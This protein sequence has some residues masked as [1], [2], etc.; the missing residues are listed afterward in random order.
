M[1]N[2]NKFCSNC[3]EKIDSKAKIRPKCGVPIAL[4][5]AGNVP[6]SGI[7]VLIYTLSIL[8]PLV[9]IIIGVIYWT[10]PNADKKAFGKACV[11]LSLIMVAI[12][13]Y[14]LRLY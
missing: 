6:T 4:L 10:K 9:G 2:E 13:S 8:L 1:A 14:L 5:T 7:R 11:S 3:G 12:W